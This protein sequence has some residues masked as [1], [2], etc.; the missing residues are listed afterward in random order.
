MTDLS[1]EF[2]STSP[3][4]A[5]ICV[6]GSDIGNYEQL[7]IDAG[8]FAFILKNNLDKLKETV[9]QLFDKQDS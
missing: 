3:D 1:N 2:K 8:A 9:Q 6:S 7:F 4:S 5:I